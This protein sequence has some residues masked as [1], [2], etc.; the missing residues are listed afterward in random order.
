MQ[1]YH[2]RSMVEST[3]SMI[4]RVL[5]D[6]LRSKTELAMKNEA[7]AKLVC[8]NLRCVVSAI[9]ELGVDPKFFGL[10]TDDEPQDII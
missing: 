3:F 5:G 9:Y 6:G 10:P 7:L 1:H 2:R 4:K 8:H